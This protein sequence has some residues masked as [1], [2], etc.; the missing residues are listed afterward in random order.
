MKRRVWLVCIALAVSPLSAQELKL[1]K[2]LLEGR[3]YVMSVAF[4]PDGKTL[5]SLG[6]DIKLW[7]VTTGRNTAT[8]NEHAEAAVTLEKDAKLGLFSM[9]FSPDGKTL[10]SGD[11]LVWPFGQMGRKTNGEIKLWNVAT[12]KNIATLK[13]HTHIVRS[14]AFSPDG[15]TLA[16]GSLDETI[17]LWD[18]SS[19]KCIA[20]LKVHGAPVSCVAY[21]PDGKTVA[22]GNDDKTVKLWDVATGKNVA[23][24]NADSGA[25]DCVCVAFSP[26]GKTVASG[27]YYGLTTKMWDVKTGQNIASIMN[28]S[29]RS[30]AYSP[31]GKT[32]A[33]GGDSIELWD[34]PTTKQ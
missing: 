26:D 18:V 34:V 22:S 17:R 6:D 29:V 20:T 10:A 7:D 5:A 3:A 28:G 13:G 4:S 15:K 23:T 11:E 32:L 16:S 9:A 2:T 27:S 25:D 24:L 33:S 30:V 14:I 19:T 1:R 12:G 31:D 8:L 21:S